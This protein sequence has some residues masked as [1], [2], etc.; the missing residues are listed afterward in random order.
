MKK[1]LAI[2][3]VLAVLAVPAYALADG[4]S[5]GPVPLD[6]V[7]D[8]SVILPFE[9]HG[10]AFMDNSL[11]TFTNGENFKLYRINGRVMIPARLAEKILY[12][13]RTRWYAAAYTTNPAGVLFANG[14]NKVAITVGSKIMKVNGKEAPLSVPA[15][16]V[17]QRIIIPLRDVFNALNLTVCWQNGMLIISKV[18][19]DLSSAQTK[20][21][22]EKSKTRLTD[23]PQDVENK[24]YPIAAYNGGYYALNSYYDQVGDYINN[25]LYYYNEGKR[26]LVNL[27]GDVKN[28]NFI[29]SGANVFDYGM[30]GQSIYYPAKTGSET[31]L[32][33]LDFATN[34]SVEICSLSGG[35][36]GWSLYSAGQFRGVIGFGNY[37]YVVLNTGEGTMGGDD[38]Y[39]LESNSLTKVGEA[40]WLNS[41]TQVGT[42]LYYT[43]LD[44]MGMTEN[45]L[46]C[47]DFTKDTQ[48]ENIAMNGYTYD[49]E[50]EKSDSSVTYRCPT[51]MDGLA[52]KDGY[53]YT[54]LYQEN[55][56][57]DNRNVVKINT[58]D[59]SQT[60]LPIEV[61]KFWLVSDGIV[62]VDFSTGKLMKSDFDGQNAKVLVDKKIDLIKAYGDHIYDTVEGEAGIYHTDAVA[63]KTEKLSNI[64]VND[65]LL[66]QPG[67]Y[68]IN[69]TYEAGIFKI[70]G[71]GAVKIADGF[72]QWYIN[73]DGGILYNK[74]GSTEMYLAK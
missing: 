35:D 18:P 34:R 53:L 16:I 50:R 8:D 40:K 2:L 39:R 42:K 14:E 1:W 17:D 5:A 41:L 38:I 51:D 58:A 44:S 11:I 33:R 31:K 36:I 43:D 45:N 63:E 72:V 29:G 28:G 56:K 65:I 10:Y 52:V 26:E 49:V 46:Y 70:S 71:S 54:M 22:V 73:T 67:C 47:Y 13:N 60:V 12:Y 69:Y 23:F 4:Q 25:K 64:V 74:R 6:Q 37:T 20:E 21:I 66:N 3:F 48:A 24:L 59:N 55:A 32:Y 15:R 7:F 9:F 30:A 62:Y 27:A 57:K 61:N 19:I 68:F